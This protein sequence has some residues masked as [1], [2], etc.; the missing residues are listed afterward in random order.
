MALINK[1]R[2]EPPAEKIVSQDDIN[3][4]EY[5][6]DDILSEKEESQVRQ[7]NTQQGALVQYSEVDGGFIAIGHTRQTL[8]PG[9]YRA[10]AIRNEIGLQPHALI[11]DTLLRMPDSESDRVLSEITR[12]WQLK[13]KYDAL[14]FTHK[15]GILLYGPPGTGKS[16]TLYLIASQ[17]VKSGDVVLIADTRPDIVLHVIGQ[18]RSV[19]PTRRVVV[20]MEDLDEL[21]NS[22]GTSTVLSM[23]DGED[24]LDNVCFVAT[25]N[26][27][28]K[29]DKRIIN[30]PSRFDLL[31]FVGYPSA[32]ARKT[33]IAS[34]MPAAHAKDVDTWV[35]KTD[36]FTIAHLKE[37]MI[38]VCLLG[39]KLD[40]EVGRLSAMIEK[41]PTSKSWG[42]GR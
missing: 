41:R 4:T 32:Q 39:K 7:S 5:L 8:T 6:A 25:T 18:L 27:P 13:D 26:H 42:E 24:S 40:D 38:G 20:L 10:R 22:Y 31:V 23:L 29:L 11:T 15:R 16:S 9:I 36:N 14:G 34:R 35:K 28:E 19:E 30:R 3:E 21:M 2:S 17:T 33:Y 12:F 37:L 1:G